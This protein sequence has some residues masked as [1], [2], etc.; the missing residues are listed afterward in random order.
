MSS[1]LLTMTLIAKDEK[2]NIKRC[3]DSWWPLVDEVVL[4]DTGSTDGTIAEAKRYAKN[5]GQ[6]G[7]LKIVNHT[8]T[9]DFSAA[10]QAADDEASGDWLI[11]ADLDDTV[12]GLDQ[13]RN[14][15]FNASDDTVGFFCV[16]D[17][18]QDPSGH[19]ISELWR[20]RAVRNNGLQ[21]TG[22]LHEHKLFTEGHLVK[23][24][25]REIRWVHHRD[26][27]VRTGER[28]L[29]ILEKWNADQPDDPR[30]LHALGMEY[31]GAERQKDASD[32]YEQYLKAETEAGERRLQAYRHLCVML[33]IQDR[34]DEAKARAMQALAE[35]W[36]WADTH[37]TLAEVAQTQAKPE[38]GLVHA[39]T[40]L[41]IG[42]P[43]TLLI[44][45]PLQYTAHPLALQG[46][47]LA[48]MGRWDEA[49]A[50]GEQVMNITP[51]YPLIVAHL[52]MWRGQLRKQN[53]G[54][55][56]LS[57]VDVLV[58]TGELLKARKLLEAIPWYIT[59]EPGIV[60][61]RGDVARLIKERT[62]TPKVAVVDRAAENFMKR[63]AA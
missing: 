30:V 3:F 40:A 15:C 63:H 13:L 2:H 59:D 35:S 20:E 26:H 16:Y 21:W 9:D 38:E 8:W 60:R 36:M 14:H 55:A 49:V 5:M 31:M 28:N 24:D 46:V 56:F 12:I 45:N 52:P 25:P 22:R 51:E 43:D 54:R 17:Y 18:A 48:Q 10:R 34:V 61:R 32:T 1:P 58:E 23:L 50:K 62:K 11:W 44:I 42:R 19:T 27:T 7:R 41:E 57:C 4:C 53:A 33:M 47:C 37:L 29:R 6:P 39:Q